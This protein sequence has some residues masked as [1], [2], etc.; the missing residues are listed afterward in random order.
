MGSGDA[1]AARVG[2]LGQQQQV[3]HAARERSSLASAQY[4]HSTRFG[5]FEPGYLV[6]HLLGDAQ[7]MIAVATGNVSWSRA[8][9]GGGRHPQAKPCSSATLKSGPRADPRTRIARK[10]LQVARES[11]PATRIARNFSGNRPPRGGGGC[12]P[13]GDPSACAVGVHPMV[14]G[15]VA[16]IGEG[17]LAPGLPRMRAGRHCHHEFPSPEIQV[18]RALGPPQ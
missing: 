17:L 8:G 4:W 2:Q 1:H 14:S 9:P 10:E 7:H 15:A 11:R 13:S 6:H 3:G 12:S 5:A 16:Q 18:F